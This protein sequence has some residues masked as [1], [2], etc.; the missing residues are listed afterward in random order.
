MKIIFDNI[1]FSLQKSG[2]ISVVWKE[3]LERILKEN[4]IDVKFIEYSSACD[5]IFRKQLEIPYACLN[6]YSSKFLSFKRYFNLD[7]KL[8]DN[9]IFHSS[10]YRIDKNSHA[11]NV[12][13]VHDFTYE[14]YIKGFKQKIHSW[15]KWK[16]INKSDGII[17]ISMNTKKDLLYYL[18]NIDESKIRVIYNGVSDEYFPTSVKPYNIVPYIEKSYALF[19]GARTS[20][21]NFELTVKSIAKTDLNLVVVGAPFTDM[22]RKFIYSCFDDKRRICNVGRIS[23]SDLNV[24]YNNAYV[25]VYP[26]EYEGFGIPVIEAQKACCPVIAYNSSSIP[27]IIGS[28][29][30]MIDKLD[31]EEI[32]KQIALLKDDSYRDM[33]IKSGI[34]N[35]KRFSWSKTYKDTIEFYKYLWE[36]K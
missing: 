21:K 28:P 2:G 18:P 7:N 13:T 20:Y 27:E 9:Y 15:Q 5:N 26:S 25:F 17:C 4:N 32:I 22:E 1:I 35:A 16:S 36:N 34:E 3:H 8:Q 10:H 19:V 33:I 30:L 24:L 11:I 12:T 31:E 14:K 29:N 6:L 23:N